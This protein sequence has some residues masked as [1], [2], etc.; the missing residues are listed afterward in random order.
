MGNIPILSLF[1]KEVIRFFGKII[2][3]MKEICF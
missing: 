1:S 2:F 3:K